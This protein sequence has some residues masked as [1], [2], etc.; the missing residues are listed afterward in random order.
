MSGGER[1]LPDHFPQAATA[2]PRDP[3]AALAADLPS[4]EE[5]ERRYTRHV[6]EHTSGNRTEAARLLGIGIST[7]WRHLKEKPAT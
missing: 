3:L 6:L 7:L 2:S 4:L 5:L 1:I